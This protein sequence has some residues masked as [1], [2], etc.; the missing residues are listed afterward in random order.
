MSRIRSFAPMLGL[1]AGLLAAPTPAEARSVRPTGWAAAQPVTVS[2]VGE[3]GDALPA[4]AHH[5]TTFVAGELG[6]RYE[7]VLTNQTPDRLEIVVSVDGRDVLSGKRA[8]FRKQRGYVI[9]PFGTVRVDGFRRSLD[10]VAAFRFA[11]IDDSFAARHGA[12]QNVGAIGIAVF[13]ERT[14]AQIARPHARANKGDKD[15]SAGTKSPP[16]DPS[17]AAPKKSADARHARPHHD[18]LGTEFGEDRTS[19]VRV[20]SFTRRDA[21]RPD[22]RTALQYDAADNLLARGVPIEHVAAIRPTVADPDPWPG[23]RDGGF[24]APPPPRRR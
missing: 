8:D 23:A 24:A 5:G 1:L 6:H 15:R 2:I 16:R 22:F 14:S 7:I 20:V 18:K 17:T 4:V 12:P 10:H 3:H 11:D 21:S 9:E 13:R 19:Q